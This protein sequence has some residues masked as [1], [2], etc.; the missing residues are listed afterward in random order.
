MVLDLSRTLPIL[1]RTPSV[2]DA[3]LGGL[4][5]ESIRATEGAETW[6]PFDV[7]GHLIHGER[8]DWIPRFETIMGKHSTREFAP[9]DRFAQFTESEGKSIAQ[10]VEEFKNLRAA[11]IVRLRAAGLT[12]ADMERTGVHPAFGEVTMAQLL[13]TW[14]VHDLDHISQI[15]RVLAKQY[16]VA[17]GPWVE[18]L[19]ILRA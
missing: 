9:F 7:V 18:Y 8:T 17:V 14:V 15:V 13:S 19:R 16:Q 2:I 3:L 1:E 4:P 5:E 12:S 10:L 6:S 11:N